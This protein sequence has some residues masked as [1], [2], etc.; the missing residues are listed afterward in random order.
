MTDLV[1]LRL[2]QGWKKEKEK[3]MD[4]IKKGMVVQLKSGGPRMTVHVIDK[5]G[6][7]CKWFNDSEVKGGYFEP[8]TLRIIKSE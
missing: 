5:S 2:G 6:V 1:L 7:F 8:E 3:N 4:E